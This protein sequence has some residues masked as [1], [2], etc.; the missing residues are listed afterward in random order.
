MRGIM[1]KTIEENRTTSSGLLRYANDYL[2][3]YEII[4]VD[5]SFKWPAEVPAYLF[6][7]GLELSFKAF[8]RTKGK[9]IKELMKLGHNL[10]EIVKECK[11]L[12][13]D[14]IN[15][16]NE[17]DWNYISLLNQQ[18]NN[19]EFEYILIGF[20]QFPSETIVNEI[21]KKIVM[22][23]KSIYQDCLDA[24]K[25]EGTAITANLPS[26]PGRGLEEKGT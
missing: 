11:K 7:H 2:K 5:S 25:S 3:A 21:L 19:K 18:Y 24:N 23:N 1:K 10:N 8:L 26:P 12:N 9:T 22:F 13:G 14:K 4:R 16:F 17:D 15:V 6:C 20:K